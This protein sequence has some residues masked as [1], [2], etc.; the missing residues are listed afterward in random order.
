MAKTDRSTCY[1]LL[2]DVV[3]CAG[4]V[5]SAQFRAIATQAC[6]LQCIVSTLIQQKV[7]P[8]LINLWLTAIFNASD[9]VIANRQ[10]LAVYV[11]RIH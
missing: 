4:D 11:V 6:I 2:T 9:R 7:A 1:W 3:C 8:Q 5:T 10:T